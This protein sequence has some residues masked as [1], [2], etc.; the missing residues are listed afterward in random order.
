MKVFLIALVINII[1][2]SVGFMPPKVHIEKRVHQ[3][4]LPQSVISPTTVP[5]TKNVSTRLAFDSLGIEQVVLI[6]AIGASVASAYLKSEEEKTE[7]VKDGSKEE[8]EQEPGQQQRPPPQQEDEEEEGQP[9]ENAVEE[10]PTYSIK[11]PDVNTAKR[12]VASTKSVVKERLQ[13]LRNSSEDTVEVK[14]EDS[15]VI[16]EE[17]KEEMKEKENKRK[18]SLVLRVARKVLLPWTKF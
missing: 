17:V 18:S 12:A 10:Q 15:N 7:E 2:L 16:E 4:I 5:R 6:G 13:R 8:S 11:S 9:D 14:L 1:R 3:L